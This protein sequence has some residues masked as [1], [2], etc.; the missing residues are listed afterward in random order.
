MNPFN[1][2]LDTPEGTK[3]LFCHRGDAPAQEFFSC[4]P[5]EDWFLV[6]FPTKEAAQRF[7]GGA[8]RP[9]DPAIF[10]GGPI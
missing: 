6:G 5:S 2:C 1:I 7:L 3:F 4:A 8:M 9:I 10:V